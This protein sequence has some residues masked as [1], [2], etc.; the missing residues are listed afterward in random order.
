MKPRYRFFGRAIA[1]AS[2]AGAVFA[3]CAEGATLDAPEVPAKPD[4]GGGSGGIATGEI[5]G[6]C[7]EDDACKEGTCTQVGDEKIC[8]TPCPPACPIGMYC[9]IIEGDSICVPDKDQQCLPCTGSVDC[10]N[11]SDQCL[12]APLGDK[13]CAIDCTTMGACPNGFT[14]VAASD[15]SASTGSGSGGGAADA[16]ADGGDAGPSDAGSSDGGATDGG[17]KPPS[18]VPYKFCVP[19]SGLSCP[20]NMKR[21]G[22]K[23]A[24][25]KESP[26]GL[27]EGEETCDGMAGKWKDCSAPP[28]TDEVCNDKDDNCNSQKDEGPPN[29]LCA[30]E[31]PPPPH[32]GWLCDKGKCVVA[33][34]EPGWTAYPPTGNPND[35]CPCFVESG[36]PNNTCASAT[37]AGLVS[38]AGGPIT[39]EG[40]LSSDQDVDVWTFDTVDTAEA[41]TNSYHVSVDFTSPMPNDEFMMDVMKGGTCVDAPMGPGSAITS[42]DW[43][44]DGSFMGPNG[45]EG[46]A[47]CSPQ[48]GVHCTDHSSTYFVRVYRRGGSTPTCTPYVITV[49]AKGGDACDFSQKCE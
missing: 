41:G 2:L 34:C 46:E 3:A 12:K 36:E 27:C 44:V 22:I 17:S 19:N 42:Y 37:S 39:L 18:G 45:L 5:G 10:K 13:F 8:T 40:T 16:G 31:G 6:P 4:G 32:A 26:A 14:C 35:G 21:D 11:P 47:P 25:F 48:G 9:A 15:Y 30:G 38:D 7:G 20:C 29:D 43:C 1:I 28:P 49:T 23:H 33:P 24:C